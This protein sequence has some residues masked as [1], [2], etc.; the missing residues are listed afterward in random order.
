MKR[1]RLASLVGELLS[2]NKE[3]NVSIDV[4][5]PTIEEIKFILKLDG[6]EIDSNNSEESCTIYSVLFD[7]YGPDKAP[8]FRVTLYCNELEG[9]FMYEY[10]NKIKEGGDK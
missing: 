5:H 1:K 7:K 6:N 9:K 4:W 2:H 8:A 3:C 10:A